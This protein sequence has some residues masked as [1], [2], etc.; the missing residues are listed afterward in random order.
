MHG[1]AALTGFR[2]LF[3]KKKRKG[4]EGGRGCTKGFERNGGLVGYV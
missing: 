4:C 2:G 3:K 1:Q